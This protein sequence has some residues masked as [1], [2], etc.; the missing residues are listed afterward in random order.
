MSKYEAKAVRLC[1][2]KVFHLKRFCF[3]L[4]RTSQTLMC[5]R[6]PHPWP[7]R[8]NADSRASCPEILSPWVW[9]SLRKSA[10]QQFSDGGTETVLEGILLEQCG[11]HWIFFQGR[12]GGSN[13]MHTLAPVVL[14]EQF[15]V[16]S[17]RTFY[18]SK[19]EIMEA[20][21]R[22]PRTTW[23]SVLLLFF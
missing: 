8:W 3:F 6:P 20:L 14:E 9:R 10:R 23:K 7:L 1:I 2:Y 22:Q 13:A 11:N 21:T 19:Q 5:R 4:W 12:E 17:R 15:G 16:G 18:E